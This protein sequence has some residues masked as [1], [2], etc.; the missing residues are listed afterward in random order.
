M[1]WA[2]VFRLSKT[3]QML[4]MRAFSLKTRRQES[5]SVCLLEDGWQGKGMGM[6]RLW[7]ALK[8]KEGETGV[9]THWL[10][11]LPDCPAV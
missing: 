10:Q 5:V 8:C 11:P 4:E 2:D 6:D 7:G 3:K 9:G 1:T